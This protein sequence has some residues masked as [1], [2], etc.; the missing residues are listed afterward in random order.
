MTGLFRA[1]VHARLSGLLRL[2]RATG[3]TRLV[4]ISGKCGLCCRV[5]GGGVVVTPKDFTRLPQN[6]TERVGKVIVLR[7]HAGVCNQ[8]ID[9]RCGCY[10][11]RPTGCR[12]YP[13]Y[14]IDGELFFDRGCPGILHDRDERPSVGNLTPIEAFLPAHRTLRKLL[15]VL[16]NIW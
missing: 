10:D 9:S 6:V 1:I 15:I 14:S 12:E 16:F 8:L 7:S 13:W 5:M 3:P 4:C 2:R 11:V